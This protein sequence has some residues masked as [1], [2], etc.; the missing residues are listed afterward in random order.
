[1]WETIELREI[2]LFLVLAEELHFG[3]T[4]ERLGMSGSRVSQML[5]RL[6]LK[7]GGQLV[8]RTSRSVQ[9]TPLGEAFARDAGAAYEQL[10]AVLVRT[11]AQTHTLVGTLRL[12]T[13]SHAAAGP[14]LLDIVA[15][16]ER[17][18]P[19]CRVELDQLDMD[20]LLRQLLAGE[21]DLIASWLPIDDRRVKIGPIL[22]SE[23]RAVA[24]APS[25]PLA[26]R[27][28]VSLEDVAD[29]SAS[30]FAQMPGELID[31]LVPPRAPSGRPIPRVEVRLRDRGLFDLVVRIRRGDVIHP[32]VPASMRDLGTGIVYVPLTGLPPLRSAL[33][34]RAGD[35]D[36]KTREL[37][38]VAEEILLP[39]DGR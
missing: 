5:R 30:V 9:L 1:M 38:R 26:D 3:R 21:A 8:H 29:F 2:R 33:I 7:V 17:R 18:H 36:A 31:T 22:A 25:H 6:E 4:A 20:D 12:L 32:T 39:R 24:V 13:F 35:A 28:E 19:E 27:A 14:H 10:A 11:H 15:E 34:S 37:L 23:P 16:F